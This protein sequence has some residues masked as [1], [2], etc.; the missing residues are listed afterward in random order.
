VKEEEDDK[1]V[2]PEPAIAVPEMFLLANDGGLI[3]RY[4][5]RAVRGY[6]PIMSKSLVPFLQESTVTITAAK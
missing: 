3:K 4:S 2:M 5:R 1:N 6:G